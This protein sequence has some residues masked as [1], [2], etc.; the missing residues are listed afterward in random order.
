MWIKTNSRMVAYQFG[1]ISTLKDT[2]KYY[3][4]HEE[5]YV[6]FGLIKVCRKRGIIGPEDFDK[7]NIVEE[8]IAR[9]TSGEIN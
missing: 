6:I 5:L 9:Y 3:L 8:K 2:N 1:G 7:W 4:T